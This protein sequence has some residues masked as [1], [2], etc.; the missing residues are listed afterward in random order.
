M[1]YQVGPGHGSM[2]GYTNF[3]LAYSPSG[4]THETCRYKDF[5][6]PEGITTPFYWE[7]N[8]LRLLFV[9]IFEVMEKFFANKLAIFNQIAK[10]SMNNSNHKIRFKN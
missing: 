7:M 2:E 3:T 10:Y 1:V 5:R 8:V 9:I 6:D 4:T